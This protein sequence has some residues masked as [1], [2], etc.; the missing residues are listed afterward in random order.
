MYKF[1]YCIQCEADYTLECIQS[2]IQSHRFVLE[3]APQHQYTLVWLQEHISGHQHW[4]TA[5]HPRTLSQGLKRCHK[6]PRVH[7]CTLDGAHWHRCRLAWRLVDRHSFEMWCTGGRSLPWFQ[8][9]GLMNTHVLASV[10]NPEQELQSKT[11]CSSPDTRPLAP[12][13]NSK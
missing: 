1:S 3:P 12:R 8:W 13:N 4:N 11:F 7:H 9:M 6:L 2:Y 5:R 10:D